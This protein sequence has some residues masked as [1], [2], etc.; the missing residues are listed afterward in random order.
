MN[1]LWDNA[2]SANTRLAYRTGLQCLLTFLTMS[3]VIFNLPNLP[4]VSEE[5][6]IYFVTHCYTSLHL[7]WSTIKLYL[8]GI[9]FHYLRAGNKEQ[10]GKDQEKAQSEKDSHS[11]N[12]GGKK[13][14]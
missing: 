14:N 10:V 5:M 6:L 8:A 3:G 4:A 1:N 2:L 11:K 13:P 12:R 7:K 9:R